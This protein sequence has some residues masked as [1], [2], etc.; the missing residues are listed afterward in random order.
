MI[1]FYRLKPT[2]SANITHYDDFENRLITTLE[3]FDTKTTKR[4]KLHPTLLRLNVFTHLYVIQT[5]R[6]M[7]CLRLHLSP[8]AAALCYY[9]YKRP[10]Y[11]T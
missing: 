7:T 8:F 5:F 6:N 9:I 4:L 11:L 2:L 1:R 10:K 3:K